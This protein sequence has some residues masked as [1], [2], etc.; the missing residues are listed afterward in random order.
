[1]EK[2]SKDAN[3]TRGSW[4]ERKATEYLISKKYSIIYNNYSCNIGEIDIIAQ[5]GE[6][7]VFVEV[8]LRTRTDKGLPCEFISR[9]KMHRII[10]TAQY[11]MMGRP[12]LSRLQMRFD[13]IEIL[14]LKSG[15]YMRHTENAFS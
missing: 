4:G 13:V 8:K 1:M 10:R 12:E 11:F 14:R 7:L 5:D 3:I 2:Y 9:A 6:F 15:V